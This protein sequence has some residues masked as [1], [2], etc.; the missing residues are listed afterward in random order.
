MIPKE[1]REAL[2]LEKLKDT[3]WLSTKQIADHFEIAFDTARRDILHLTATGQAVRVH[4]GIM[5]AQK[6]EIPEFLNRKRILS[7]VKTQ[8][9]KIAAS[10]V[11]PGKL[12]FIGA[13]T[14]L[15]QM[16]DLLG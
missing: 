12:Y 6:N 5:A 4:G 1:K 10:Y 16:C 3:S 8:M 7:P 14:T 11:V 9:A 2:I 13:S 15:V